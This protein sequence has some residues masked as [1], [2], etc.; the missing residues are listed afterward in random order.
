[1]T[2]YRE[3]R[4]GLGADLRA[5]RTGAGLT[6]RDLAERIG[7]SYSTLSRIENGRQTP[8]TGDLTAISAATGQENQ[9]G[10]FIARLR[11]LDT[12][13]IA[14]RRQLATGAA[15]R[16]RAAIDGDAGVRET[17]A[18]ETAVIPG[19][20][21][22]ADYARAVLTSGLRQHG[23]PTDDIE[24]AVAARIARQQLLHDSD[25]RLRILLWEAAL[26]VLMTP[27]DVMVAQ[28]NRIAAVTT[29][30]AVDL[31]ILPLGVALDDMPLH[32]FWIHRRGPSPARPVGS[33]VVLVETISAELRIEDPA[34]VATYVDVYERLAARAVSGQAARR[35]LARAARRI[36][37]EDLQQGA[38]TPRGAVR[39]L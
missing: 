35:L 37:G 30:A 1:M 8:T 23:A 6:L 16:A 17:W 7:R 15:A 25:H 38:T 31:A 28:L 22:T 9:A 33:D 13:Y 27:R 32:G 5:L 12:H 18:C 39:S 19:L 24:V 14:W 4:A 21:Q 10:E 2:D 34:D 36:A 29:L 20:L 11:A 3:A 26:Y